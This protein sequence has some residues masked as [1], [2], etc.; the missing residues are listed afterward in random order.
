MTH[1]PANHPPV[2][3]RKVGVLFMNLGTPEATDYFSMRRY[4][5]EF[6]WDKRVIEVPRFIWWFILNVIILSIRPAVKGKVY[7]SIW[8]NERNESPLKTFTRDQSDGLQARMGD[9]VIVDW[10]M[11][12]GKPDIDTAIKNMYAKGVDKLL[13]APL[14]PQYSAATTATANDHVFRTL[15]KMRHQPT[16]RSLPAYFDH[17]LYIEALKDSVL[18]ALAKLDFTPDVI[19]ASFHGVPKVYLMK[20]DPYHCHAQKTG[21]LLREALGYS[22]DYMRT[23]FQSRFGAQEWLQPYTD[24]TVEALAKSGVKKIA[25]ISPGFS[26]D[27]I[28]TLEEL[29]MENREIFIH[30]GGEK[31]AYLPCLNATPRSL[32]MIEE[33]VRNELKGWI[34]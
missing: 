11:R 9:A 25:I 33:L 1:L 3:P 23:T 2:Q 4:L 16:I 22:P 5:K 27:C 12:Y 17:P 34:S 10:A 7:A 18:E 8:N 24:K 15:M 28:E 20:G 6:L 29:D 30:N 32:D 14:Y 26:S 31:F 21:R 13:I 19:L